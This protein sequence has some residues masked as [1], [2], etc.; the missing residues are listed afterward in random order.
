MRRYADA[1]ADYVQ[2]VDE[3]KSMTLQNSDSLR[4]IRK[5]ERP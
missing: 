1:Q 2:A 4:R 3:V 5:L